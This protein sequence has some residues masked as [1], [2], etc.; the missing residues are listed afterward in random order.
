[1]KGKV[2]NQKGEGL[3]GVTVT[4]KNATTATSTDASGNYSMQVA[5]P[6]VTLVFTMVGF[7]D[8]EMP[9]NGQS[10]IDVQLQQGATSMNE[11]VVVGY[12]SQRKKDLTGAIAVV[13]VE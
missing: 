9:V 13:P 10:S 1:V 3:E 8:Q 7:T 4:V 5:N 6:K 11:V 2:T 12:G